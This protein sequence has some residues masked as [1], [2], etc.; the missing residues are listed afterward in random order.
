MPS[1]KTLK[2]VLILGIVSLFARTTYEAEKPR[3]ST[4]LIHFATGTREATVPAEVYAAHIFVPVRV[5]RGETTWF[6]LDTGASETVISK[7]V[8]EKT[9]LAFQWETGTEGVTGSTLVSTAKNVLLQLPG[10]EVPTSSVAVV[11]L[12]FMQQTLGRSVDGLLG[13]DVISHFVVQL[14]YEHHRVTFHDPATFIP[15]RGSAALAIALFRD[16]P[17]VATRILLPGRGPVEIK[18]LID[19]GAGSLILAPSFVSANRVL[20]SVGKT[21][22]VSD[23]HFGGESKELAA[24][25]G[26]VQFGPYVL[27]Q[28]VTIMPRHARGL[29]T[30]PDVDGL[31]GGEILSRFTIAFDYQNQRIL[32]KPVGHFTDPF[33]ADASGL[34]LRVKSAASGPIEIDN[35]ASDSRAATAGLQKG[36]V[37][38]AI[39]GHSASEFDLDRVRKMFQQS[40]R[41]IRLTIE[42]E[43]KTLNVHLKLQARI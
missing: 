7:P 37:I 34:S 15:D 9:G 41:D 32:F 27:R 38:T 31:I 35:V 42:R 4:A 20:E 8:A 21:T 17:Q 36:D 12:S 14:D 29:L 2:F 10:V 33:R 5:N 43:G 26:W 6:V 13:Y 22:T 39:D 3:Q 23:L 30:S 19:S 40:G 1:S 18:C 16:V 25:I 24:R 11:D 28:P